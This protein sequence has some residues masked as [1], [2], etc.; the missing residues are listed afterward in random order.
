MLIAALLACSNVN[1]S[2]YP[3][4]Y[5]EAYC[6]YLEECEGSAFNDA[7]SDLDDCVDD[8][9]DDVDTDELEDC[10]FDADKA[11]SCLE[12]VKAAKDECDPDE[13]DDDDCAEV[14][15]DCSAG[16]FGGVTVDNFVE[17]YLE[18]YCNAGCTADIRAVCDSDTTD[19]TETFACDFQADAA[20]ACVDPANWTCE[21]LY[22]GDSVTYPTPPAEC[23]EVCPY[24]S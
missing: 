4:R 5:A 18:A 23:F 15:T 21:P 9:L 3:D 19:T 24:T 1:E 6:G 16:G 20:A 8:F 2:N 22:S 17:L 13:L 7:F 11:K 10:D 14:F 12:S